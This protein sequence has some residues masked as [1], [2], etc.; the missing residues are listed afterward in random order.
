MHSLTL[1]IQEAVAHPVRPD[2]PHRRMTLEIHHDFDD[3][4]YLKIECRDPIEGTVFSA[5]V[6]VDTLRTLL[7]AIP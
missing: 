7:K 1:A 4:T 6:P 5:E 2:K 3:P